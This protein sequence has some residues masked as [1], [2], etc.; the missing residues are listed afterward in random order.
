MIFQSKSYNEFGY[1]RRG[2]STK[3]KRNDNRVAGKHFQG[4]FQGPTSK[5]YPKTNQKYN[6]LSGNSYDATPIKDNGG[7]SHQQRDQSNDV[8]ITGGNCRFG[9]NVPPFPYRND[10]N[11]PAHYGPPG[12]A[13]V[14]TTPP[15][16]RPASVP[17]VPVQYHHQMHS[18]S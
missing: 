8:D 10:P 18:V 17:I 2:S 7:K 9:S 13:Y 6:N 3:Y 5:S 1:N 15:V 11:E 14:R 16:G 4:S 12:N